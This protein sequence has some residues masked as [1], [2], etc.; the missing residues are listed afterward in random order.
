MTDKDKA[1]YSITAILIGQTQE[2]IGLLSIF[3]S[4]ELGPNNK[5]QYYSIN[6][7][8]VIMILFIM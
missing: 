7:E 1:G 2:D 6:G 4:S 3:G 5:N 8:N